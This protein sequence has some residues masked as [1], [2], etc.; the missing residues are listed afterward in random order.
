MRIKINTPY[1][2]ER[3]NMW[4]ACVISSILLVFCAI[5]LYISSNGQLGVAWQS[6]WSLLNQIKQENFLIFLCFLVL[7]VSVCGAPFALAAAIYHYSRRIKNRAYFAYMNFLEAGLS[8]ENTDPALSFFTPYEELGCSLLVT[9]YIQ[10]GSKGAKY[11]RLDTTTL[12]FHTPQGPQTIKHVGTLSFIRQI[13]D[14]APHFKS[15]SS[16]VRPRQNSYDEDE[17]DLVRYVKEQ[18]YN[19]QTYGKML[20][21]SAAQR[22]EIR[23]LG[24]IL[25]GVGIFFTAYVWFSCT[26]MIHDALTKGWYVGILFLLSGPVMVL[27]PGVLM[28]YKVRQDEKAEKEINPSA[29]R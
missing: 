21:Y 1:Q 18:I 27:I 28:I 9:T 24:W 12:T 26:E 10:H 7:L 13:L 11:R 23:L 15:F 5:I 25:V 17:Q 4:I 16:E 14:V 20:R 29:R 19:Y 8:L 6:V 22:K 3:R 2:Q